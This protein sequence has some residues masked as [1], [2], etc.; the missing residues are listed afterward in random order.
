MGYWWRRTINILTFGIAYRR[1]SNCFCI[2][3]GKLV[4][5]KHSENMNRRDHRIVAF[6]W[7][8]DPEDP[9]DLLWRRIFKP[10]PK[11]PEKT[12]LT[13]HAGKIRDQGNEGSCVGQAGAALKDWYE[14]YQRGYPEGGLSSRCIYN[15]ARALEGRLKDEGAYLRDALK[16]LQHYGT[17]GEKRWPYRPGVDTDKDPRTHIAAQEMQP[18]QIESYVRINTVEEI[19]QAL[20]AGRPVY[21]GVPWYRNWITPGL[22]GKLPMPE[23]PP[24]GGHAILFLGYNRTEDWLLFQ[25]S[26]GRLW[27]KAGYGKIPIKALHQIEGEC[28]FW[29]VIDKQG[30]G[31][32]PGPEPEPIEPEWRKIIKKILKLLEQLQKTVENL[33][34][35][36]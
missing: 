14:K 22:D 35:H 25:N 2:K 36:A 34:K 28:D 8:K 26:W 33:K 4:S 9:R 27:G 21:A 17:C 7:M 30:P 11:I 13:H 16:G 12:D 31:P 24:V 10:P 5:R 6:G 32:G 1:Y 29:T 20:A 18:W 15:L 23:G 3:C 19:L